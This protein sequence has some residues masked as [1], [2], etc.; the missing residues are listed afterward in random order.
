VRYGAL[1]GIPALSLV[2]LLALSSTIPAHAQEAANVCPV[3][4]VSPIELSIPDLPLRELFNSIIAPIVA[5]AMVL[6]VLLST[7]IGNIGRLIQSFFYEPALLFG[8]PRRKGYLIVYASLSKKPVDLALVRV[9][10]DAT[11]KVVATKVTAMDG[12][13]TFFVPE[14]RYRFAVV[15]RGYGFPTKYLVGE[16]LDPAIGPIYTGTPVRH[17]G[18]GPLEINLPIDAPED[19]VTVN[20]ALRRAFRRSFHAAVAYISLGI[21]IIAAIVGWKWTS[22]ALLG[23]HI[24]LFLLFLRLTHRPYGRPWGHVRDERTG[25]WLH[26]AVVRILD[27]RFNKVLETVVTDRR[28]QYNFAVGASSYKLFSDRP[29]YQT[30]RSEQFAITQPG[31]VISKHIHMRPSGGATSASSGTM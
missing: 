6:N 4:P 9:V 20:Q 13:A 8:Q 28:G 2:V 3:V 23:L 7:P 30:Y 19:N 15:K 24:V 10:N 17:S 18:K 11:G 16:T 25:S 31:G 27:P 14:G 29:G 21:G 5:V 1:V 26:R 12:R 22:F